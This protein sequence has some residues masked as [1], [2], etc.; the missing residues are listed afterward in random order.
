MNEWT[1]KNEL[2]FWL[3]RQ[4]W[5]TTFRIDV[6]VRT[7]TKTLI[8]L[9][10]LFVSIQKMVRGKNFQNVMV[11]SSHAKKTQTFSLSHLTFSAPFSLSQPLSPL[12]L[13]Q[14]I[15]CSKIISSFST[16]FT[17][18][19]NF[20]LSFF[21]RCLVASGSVPFLVLEKWQKIHFRDKKCR[22][23]VFEWPTD[24][25]AGRQGRRN[26]DNNT[27]SGQWRYRR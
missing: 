25:R 3:W 10:F 17:A 2:L 7:E 12:S 19:S 21:L 4:N 20:F 24:R 6:D 5:G 16:F 9:S 8:Y 15:F 1:K 27:D 11:F 26:H 23:W 14:L 22:K 13:D 18:S